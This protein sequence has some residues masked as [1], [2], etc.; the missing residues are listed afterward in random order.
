MAEDLERRPHH[1]AGYLCL[2]AALQALGRQGEAIRC[3]QRAIDLHP[4]DAHTHFSL[5]NALLAAGKRDEALASYEQALALDPQYAEAHARVA[6]RLAAQGKHDDAVQMFNWGLELEPS[7]PELAFPLSAVQ[8]TCDAARA[9]DEFIVR[10][11]DRFADTFDDLLLNGLQ[12]RTPWLLLEAVEAVVRTDA[13]PLDVLD[14]GCGTG[15]CGPL[16]RPLA[17]RL[18]G[19]DLSPGMLEKA[20]A[21]AVYDELRAEE[22]TAALQAERDAYDLIVS[23]D[24]LVYFGDLAQVFAGAVGALRSA[25]LL[26]VSVELRD[27]PGY[28]LRPSGRYAH[29]AAY[30]RATASAVGLEEVATRACDLRLELGKPLAGY[31]AVFRKPRLGSTAPS[32]TPACGSA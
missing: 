28:A 6:A 17:R 24:V 21:R 14:A 25:G 11:F 22:L 13:G 1:L 32:T 26:A 30:L 10:H 8:G 19:I 5:A 3:F 31:V 12:Y 4:Q 15:L 9:P 29:S 16:F 27:E 20:G 7:N 18:V 23:A 2:G